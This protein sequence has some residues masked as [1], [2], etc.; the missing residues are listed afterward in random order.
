MERMRRLF[1][2]VIQSLL[3]STRPLEEARYVVFGAPLDAAASHRSGTRFAPTSIRQASLYM[4]TGSP[5]TGLDSED[6]SFHDAG[7]LQGM[8]TIDDA[9]ANIEEAFGH[10]N[11]LGKVPVMMGGEHTVTLGALRALDPDLVIVFDAHMDMRDSLLG[12]KMSHGTF[13][14]R[15]L[16]ELDFRLIEIGVR[17]ISKEEVAYAEGHPER[18][19]V[20]PSGKLIREGV[21]AT[22]KTMRP[23]L[24]DASSVYISVDMDVVDPASAPAVGNP[25]PEGIGVTPLLDLMTLSASGRVA[26]LDLTEVTP[27]YD[28][29]LTATHAAYILLEGLCVLEMSGSPRERQYMEPR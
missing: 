21:E 11:N 26:G 1:R 23:W 2:P 20:V 8:D 27:F 18:I 3:E 25:S 13:M 15:A 7:D 24:S 6:I 22:Y 12:S 4:E 29:G 19:S 14:R 28:S 9:L 5:R 10:L 17:A 16:E